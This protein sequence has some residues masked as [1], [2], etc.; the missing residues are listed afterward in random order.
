MPAVLR[1]PTTWTLTGFLEHFRFVHQ[2]M[3]DHA[4]AWVLGAGA[5]KASGIPLAGELVQRWLGEL[6][7]RATGGGQPLAEWATADNLEIPD[8]RYEQAASFYSR[9]YE[10]RFADNP[11]EG[12][13]YL[14]H[15]MSDKDPSPGYSLLAQIL[16]K[17][18]HKVCIST[19]FDNLVADALSIYTSTFP[20]NIGHE[21]LAS[22]VKVVNRRPVVCKIHRDLLLGPKNDTRSL[23]RLHES[24]AAAL[25][26]LFAQFTP[27]FIG[28]GGNDD[29]LMD[30]LESLDP[31]DI[32]GQMI[33]CYYER[34]EPSERIRELI[35]QHRGALVPVPDFDMLMILLGAELGLEPIDN[36]IEER[37]KQRAQR[38]RDR[39]INL[40]TTAYPTVRRTLQGAFE[41][42]GGPLVWR[43]KATDEPS[44]DRREAIFRQGLEQYPN[45]QWLRFEFAAFMYYHDRGLTETRER[46]T[47]LLPHDKELDFRPSFYLAGLDVDARNLRAAE[48]TLSRMQDGQYTYLKPFALAILRE[49]QG[50]LVEAERLFRELASPGSGFLVNILA[51]FLWRRGLLDEAEQCFRGAFDGEPWNPDNISRLATFLWQARDDR[52]SAAHL[53][54]TALD[55]TASTNLTLLRAATFFLAV[56]D[57]SQLRTAFSLMDSRPMDSSLTERR[58]LFVRIAD[59]LVRG[60]DGKPYIAQMQRM[61]ARD[62]YNALPAP[63][64]LAKLLLSLKP[65][66]APADFDFLTALDIAIHDPAHKPALA[67]F[68]R[69]GIT[70]SS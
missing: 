45:D 31:G 41:R 49:V 33:W 52:P 53:F 58:V 8:F 65:R 44:T 4:Y 25:R 56:G 54:R 29:S 37:A 5:S 35:K 69:W 3:R 13:A 43:N 47:S 36:A 64:L 34:S 7:R 67:S 23:R 30:L 22:F 62:Y 18:P 10:R 42:A 50:D 48:R 66:L 63:P 38:Y 11:D 21:S 19:N 46:L 32:K 27:L 60:R 12:Y 39:L 20:L 68:S 59:G 15:L 24:W 28:Y 2:S 1:S 70:P 40:D 16:E 61:L 26:A 57:T 9:V 17:T 14:E 51:E 6:H 55:R